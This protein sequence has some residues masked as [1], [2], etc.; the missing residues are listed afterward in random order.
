MRC[1]G[2]TMRLKQLAV[3]A[4]PVRLGSGAGS[5]APPAGGAAAAALRSSRPLVEGR[6]WRWVPTGPARAVRLRAL[7]ELYQQVKEYDSYETILHL[8]WVLMRKLS[9]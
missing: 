1:T 7:C 5:A 3:T 6:L 2:Q 8:Q 9:G 4:A